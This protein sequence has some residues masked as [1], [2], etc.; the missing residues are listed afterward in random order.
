MPGTDNSVPVDSQDNE[1]FMMAALVVWAIAF[2]IFFL[3]SIWLGRTC[4]SLLRNP[5]SRGLV[6]ILP[7]EIAAIVIT[8]IVLFYTT[9][10]GFGPGI[11]LLIPIIIIAP[12]SFFLAVSRLV[13][14]LSRLLLKKQVSAS[15]EILTMAVLGILV[16]SFL[17]VPIPGSFQMTNICD[18]ID[19]RGGERISFALNTYKRDLGTYPNQIASLVPSHID[20]IPY[21]VCNLPYDVVNRIL[22]QSDKNYPRYSLKLPFRLNF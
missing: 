2:I 13:T 16:P 21:N 5:T 6:T 11:I 3:T 22:A 20:S 4:I 10:G 19:R 1:Y 9:G 12:I 14:I 7:I 8:S 15:S 18:E 17:L